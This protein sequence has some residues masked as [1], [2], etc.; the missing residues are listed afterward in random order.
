MFDIKIRDSSRYKNTSSPDTL[1]GVRKKSFVLPFAGGEIWFEH[2][3]GMYQFTELVI[4]KLQNDSK[5]FLLPSKPSHIGFVLDETLIT[6]D[7]VNKIVNLLCSEQKK[8]M[9][10]CFIG[11]DRKIRK[12]FNNALYSKSNF[13]Y[14]FINDFEK[15]KEW[16]ILE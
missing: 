1:P 8:Y 2:L 13:T 5:T 9:R 7:L 14:A 3:D 11:T 15:A 16:L 10:V 4:Q 6:N 12:M